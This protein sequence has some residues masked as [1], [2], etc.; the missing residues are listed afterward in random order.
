MKLGLLTAAFPE[1]TLDEIAEWAAAID[2]GALEI[3]CWPAG[4]GA[5]RQRPPTR[6]ADRA[7]RAARCRCDGPVGPHLLPSSSP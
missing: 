7:D 2:F 6:R 3:A 1:L 5:A 4:E